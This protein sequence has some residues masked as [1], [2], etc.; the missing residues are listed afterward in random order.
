MIPGRK[1]K[2]SSRLPDSG[3]PRLLHRPALPQGSA[4]A[5]DLHEWA[6]RVQPLQHRLSTAWH[7]C[8]QLRGQ[9]S[10]V[11]AAL[12][13]FHPGRQ[14]DGF[15][16]TFPGGSKH[17]RGAENIKTVGDVLDYIKELVEAAGEE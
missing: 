15:L 17:R 11:Q 2:D 1:D 13:L 16:L 12:P 14:N 3:L 7:L 4:R 10:V 5:D 6:S 9:Q 8:P